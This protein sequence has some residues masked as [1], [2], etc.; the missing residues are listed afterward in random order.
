MHTWIPPRSGGPESQGFNSD[1]CSGHKR[2]WC[3]Y[4]VLTTVNGAGDSR[5]SKTQGESDTGLSSSKCYRG[6]MQQEPG[7]QRGTASLTEQTLSG[8]RGGSLIE[9]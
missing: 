7:R 6:G 8:L 2:L 3:A 5:M 4:C 1:V 9:P